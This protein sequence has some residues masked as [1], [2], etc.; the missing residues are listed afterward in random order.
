MVW[1]SSGQYLQGLELSE[2]CGKALVVRRLVR[3][4]E[5][6]QSVSPARWI[7]WERWPGG[8]GYWIA[9]PSG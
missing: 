5:I 8:C 1:R 9:L 6:E 7:L 3:D 2:S 4:A